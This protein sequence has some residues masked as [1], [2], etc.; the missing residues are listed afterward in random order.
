LLLISVNTKENLANCLDLCF[1]S[2]CNIKCDKG[3]HSRD[4]YR[5]RLIAYI[6]VK[7]FLP[8]RW[9]QLYTDQSRLAGAGARR[10]PAQRCAGR[11]PEGE[12]HERA[13]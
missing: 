1:I 3:H 5:F 13:S 11:E 10:S 12:N 8:F 9:Q 2:I 4:K 6:H 7:L